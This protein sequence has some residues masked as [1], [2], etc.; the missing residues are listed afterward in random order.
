S[1]DRSSRSR[2]MGDLRFTLGAVKDGAYAPTL[3]LANGDYDLAYAVAQGDLDVASVNPSSFLSM[4]YRGK[5]LFSE[6]LPLR[7]IAVMPSLDVMLFAISKK[8]GITSLADIKERRCPLRVSVRRSPIHG[9]RFVLD[10]VF[11]AN[12]FSLD[13]LTAWGGSIHYGE[14][15]T[16]Q[17]R[18]AGVRDGSIDAV[19]DEAV[20][21]W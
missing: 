15:P 1:M 14:S 18:L 12:G 9:T 19:F 3:S 13:D 21:G 11:A 2:S 20:T 16:D 8:T 4:A 7:A 10:Q 17:T 6:A 5:G